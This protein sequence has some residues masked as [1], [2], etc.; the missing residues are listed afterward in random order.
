MECQDANVVNVRGVVAIYN[1]KSFYYC[2]QFLTSD[3]IAALEIVDSPKNPRGFMRAKLRSESKAAADRLNKLCELL[4]NNHYDGIINGFCDF[5]EE[6]LQFEY[7]MSKLQ[8]TD[9]PLYD[10]CYKERVGCLHN[11][12]S[13]YS[14]KLLE[15]EGEDNR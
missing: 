2:Q 7:L 12:F 9:V 10:I 15:L 14:P 6:G 3:E 11:D 8:I 1:I 5:Y 4:K 13:M